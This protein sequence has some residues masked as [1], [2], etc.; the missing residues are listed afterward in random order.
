MESNVPSR[1][2][3]IVDSDGT[4]LLIATYIAGDAAAAKGSARAKRGNNN[5]LDTNIVEAVHKLI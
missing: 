3:G 2:M 4:G 1:A 5:C